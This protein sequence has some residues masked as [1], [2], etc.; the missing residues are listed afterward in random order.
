MGF[1]HGSL[2]QAQVRSFISEVW[3]Y[4]EEQVEEYLSGI[5]NWLSQDIAD[6]GLEVALDMTVQ[7]TQ[8][9]T[10]SYFFEELQGMCASCVPAPRCPE[11][12]DKFTLN[13]AGL[14][15]YSSLLRFLLNLSCNALFCAA[16][17][18]D[19]AGVD[20]QTLLRI[21]MIGELTQV[22]QLAPLSNNTLLL[23]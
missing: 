2:M 22:C 9:F 3:Q 1:A 8:N 21:H 20:Y 10:G 17:I 18:A 14:A 23:W 16:G 12:Y 11:Q 15:C 6:F 5:P 4:F 7:L 19:G 13:P